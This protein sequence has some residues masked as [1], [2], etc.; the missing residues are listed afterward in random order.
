MAEKGRNSPKIGTFK[1]HKMYS[2]GLYSMLWNCP[3][4]YLILYCVYG[5]GGMTHH[6]IIAWNSSVTP[7]FWFLSGIGCGIFTI[8]SVQCI[9]IWVLSC[10]FLMALDGAAWQLKLNYRK[11][12]YAHPARFGDRVRVSYLLLSYSRCSGIGSD[13]FQRYSVLQV[14]HL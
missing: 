14:I 3:V 6:L 5:Y 7:S 13:R 9:A 12:M 4:N 8:W 1:D 10:H 11:F 2:C